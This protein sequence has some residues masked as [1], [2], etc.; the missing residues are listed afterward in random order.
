MAGKKVNPK[1]L[2]RFIKGSIASAHSREIVED[3]LKSEKRH[4]TGKAARQKLTGMVAQKGRVITVGD[5]RTSFQA[6]EESELQKAEAVAQ[7]AINVLQ[8]Q[9]DLEHKKELG[10]LKKF[11]NILKTT[12]QHHAK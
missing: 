11:W 6:R 12:N 5:V 8:R 1:Y 3:E 10:R 4:A 7:R 2:S 9:K